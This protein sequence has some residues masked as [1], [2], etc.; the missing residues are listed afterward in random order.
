M[1]NFA[2]FVLPFCKIVG[3]AGSMSLKLLAGKPSGPGTLF[4]GIF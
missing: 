4:F 2:L 1:S 3:L